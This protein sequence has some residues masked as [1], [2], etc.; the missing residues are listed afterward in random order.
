MGD[1]ASQPAPGAPT[2]AR[3]PGAADQSHTQTEAPEEDDA[4]TTTKVRTKVEEA[5]AAL[6]RHGQ[7]GCSP[8][9]VVLAMDAQEELRSLDVQPLDDNP[10]NLEGALRLLRL[11]RGGARWA[12]ARAMKAEADK[13]AL[14]AHIAALE[15]QVE[16]CQSHIRQAATDFNVPYP[17]S[18]MDDLPTLEAAQAVAAASGPRVTASPLSPFALAGVA[19]QQQGG[20]A[21]SS[22]MLAQLDVRPTAPPVDPL[23][24]TGRCS[25]AGEGTCTWCRTHASTPEAGPVVAIAGSPLAVRPPVQEKVP[26]ALITHEVPTV[27]VRSGWCENNGHVWDTVDGALPSPPAEARC[28][29]CPAVA[30][31]LAQVVLSGEAEPS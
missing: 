2:P 5:V 29:H 1:V 7:V 3:S 30:A 15:Q 20:P 27:G 10:D 11:W 16:S 22:R 17:A 18:L 6:L 13:A 24:P 19:P 31:P 21:P 28:L 9:T 25:C 8:A 14:L 12:N 26:G 23:H 4:M